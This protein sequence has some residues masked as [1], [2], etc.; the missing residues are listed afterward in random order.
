[1]DSEQNPS[2]F[3]LKVARFLGACATVITAVTGLLAI[4]DAAGYLPKRHP[5][6]PQLL[7]HTPIAVIATDAPPQPTIG[8]HELDP[9]EAPQLEPTP[10]MDLVAKYRPDLKA[11]IVLGDV[12]EIQAR[13]YLDPRPLHTIFTGEALEVELAAIQD[14]ANDG[15]FVIA[16]LENQDYR[17]FK[18]SDDGI[19]AEVQLVETWSAIAYSI[20]NQMC[21]ARFPSQDAPQTVFL[22]RRANGWL[23]YAIDHDSTPPAPISC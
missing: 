11:A 10:T 17:S 19:Y 14:L 13:R 6:G 21:V 4:L 2:S 15:I 8:R 12:A 18:V 5:A 7:E 23:I 9:T 16:R 1:M 20:V 22:E 3:W